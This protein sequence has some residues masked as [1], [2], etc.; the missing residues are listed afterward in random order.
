MI[1]LLG[2]FDYIDCYSALI[3]LS[4]L[5]KK[6][7]PNL[8]KNSKLEQ[9][10]NFTFGVRLVFA[11]CDLRKI[12]VCHIASLYTILIKLQSVD[13]ERYYKENPSLLFSFKSY[14]MSRNSV[15]A[16][17][18]E[19]TTSEDDAQFTLSKIHRYIE[20]SVSPCHGIWTHRV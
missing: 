12:N 16:Q 7:L 14:K 13:L 2:Y 4:I 20:D 15:F 6:I 1:I 3:I 9:I 10:E 11:C 5:K 18:H 19:A 17:S 8:M